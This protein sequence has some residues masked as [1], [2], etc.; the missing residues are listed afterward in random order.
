MRYIDEIVVHCSATRPEWMSG[1]GLK[2]QVEEITRWHVDD[3]GWLDIGYHELIGRDGDMMVGRDLDDDGDPWEHQGAGVKGHNVTTIHICLIGGHGS[4]EFDEFSDHFTA[5]Q[6]DKL[7]ER[8]ALLKQRF[9]TIKKV[10]GH[11]QY[12]AKACPGFNVPR[13]L[14]RRAPRR[15]NPVESTTIQATGG[16]AVA[17]TGGVLA[18]IGSLDPTAQLVALGVGA[19]ILLCLG[20]IARERLRKFFAGRR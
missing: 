15:E 8:I 20:W 1:H 16:A 10:S 12:A 7:R 18:A 13:W 3:R 2:E 14:E 4:A 17:T 6:E 5:A 11:N 19:F 9:P